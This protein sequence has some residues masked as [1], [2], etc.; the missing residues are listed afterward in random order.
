M[1]NLPHQIFCPGA[2]VMRV[3]ILLLIIMV[4]SFANASELED[5]Y[6]KEFA[7]LVAEKKALEQR[8]QSLKQTQS[9][10][11]ENIANEIDQL[12]KTFLSKQNLTDR[13]NKRIVDASRDVDHVENDAVLLDTTLL[14]AKESLRKLDKSIEETH[15]VDKQLAQALTLANETLSTDGS[16]VTTQGT[17]FLT[18]GVAVEGEIL[19]IGR[20]A[21]YGIST[22]GSGALAPAGDGLFKVWDGNTAYAAESVKSGE[23]SNIDVFLFDNAEKGIE[24]QDEKTFKDDVKAAGLVG[25]VIVAIGV[26][27]A[28]LVLLRVIMLKRAGANIQ[29]LAAKVNERIEQGDLDGALQACEKNVSAVSK[30]IAATLRNLKRDRDHIEDIISESILHESSYIDRFGTT[31]LVIAAIAPLLGL[32]GTVT[33]MISTF[34]IIT[35]FG[36]GDPKLL[37]SGIS[38]ALLT[39]KFGLI[40]AI[41]M[42]LVGNLLSSWAKQIKNDLEQAAL[43]MINTHKC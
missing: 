39:T 33:G 11:L 24:K 4:G 37:S 18:N 40:V 8:L 30:V 25:N 1:G 32:L 6:Q 22:Q 16:V 21:K 13:L 12:Q 42:L 36:T 43:H 27:G 9:E 10:N 28:V 38:E 17:F 23:V 5:A 31:I 3:L 35:E 7:Y 2:D 29:K 26:I 19:N 20:I 15:S 14:Q 34:D 41:P